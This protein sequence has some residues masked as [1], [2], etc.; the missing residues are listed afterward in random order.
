MG[1]ELASEEYRGGDV[2][3]G[4]ARNGVQVGA[5]RK[6]VRTKKLKQPVSLKLEGVMEAG[7]L[8]GRVVRTR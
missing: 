8:R 5:A 7:R 3:G 6:R 1:S 4:G 2:M